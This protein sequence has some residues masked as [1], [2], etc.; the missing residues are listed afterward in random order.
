MKNYLGY[1]LAVFLCFSLDSVQR[2]QAQQLE[3]AEPAP[4]TDAIRTSPADHSTLLHPGQLQALV[5]I[6]G[7]ILN[8]DSA[9]G[10]LSI[11][12]TQGHPLTIGI[13]STTRILD[14]KNHLLHLADLKSADH[15]R[16]YY[17]REDNQAQQIDL[18]PSVGDS[19][20]GK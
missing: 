5:E 17:N 2:L 20:L 9:K 11:K 10:L 15:I 7:A 16:A 13:Q 8:L 3:S 18:L 14:S 4:K 12:D 6:E 1:F 19:L